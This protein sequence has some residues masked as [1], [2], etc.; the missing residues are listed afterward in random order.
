MQPIVAYLTSHTSRSRYRQMVTTSSSARRTP[1]YARHEHL[2]ARF[3]P[4][5]GWSMPLEYE[6]GGTV[7]EHTAVRNAVGVFDVSHMGAFDVAGPGA[8]AALNEVLTNDL[9]KVPDGSAQYTLL[10]ASGGGVIDDMI[11]Y[12]VDDEHVHIVPNAA[13]ASLVAATVESVL[14]THERVRIDDRGPARCLIAVQGP[15]SRAVLE[16]VGIAVDLAYMTFTTVQW[17]S[18]EVMVARSG[19]TGEHGYE[20]SVPAAAGSDLWDA[21]LEPVTQL[22]GLPCGLAAR[23][24]LRTEMG[25][26]LHGHELS[27]EISPVEA[28]LSWAIGWNKPHFSGKAALVE[29]K[30]DPYTFRI[31]ALR[32]VDRGI[33]RS[34]MQV[35]DSADPDARLLGTVTSGTFS[36]TLKG[37]I[38]LAR[39]S[40]DSGL[41]AEV[42]VDVRGRRCR[43]TIVQAPFVDANPRL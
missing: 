2:G 18:A 1:L 32:L 27:L 13:N 29:Q 39:L 24:T 11:V 12:V 17:N 33:P 14:Q 28:G 23:D 20:L 35:Y 3:A 21:L 25:Y 36:P 30:N 9:S 7:A 4:F 41:D 42:F 43:A 6:A 34:G 15:Q 10:C 16:A 19:Y 38:A 22:G 37:G 5:G 26:P 31:R 8:R 40:P